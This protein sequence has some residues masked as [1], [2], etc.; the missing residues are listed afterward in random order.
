M[1]RWENWLVLRQET[2]L[3]PELEILD[4]HHHLWDRGGHTYLPAQLLSDAAG[5]HRLV[6]SVYVECLSSYRSSG[7]EHLRP[8]GETEYVVSLSEQSEQARVIGRAYQER[9]DHK[10]T[11][12]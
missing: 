7:P 12:G 6:G 4:A 2:A 9:R 10:L 5:G 1:Q 3:D 8:V 11:D